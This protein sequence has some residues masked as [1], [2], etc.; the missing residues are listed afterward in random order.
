MLVRPETPYFYGVKPVAYP[1]FEAS[2]SWPGEFE[3]FFTANLGYK[4][5][6]V[7]LH[8]LLGYRVL[9]DLQGD[10]VL[11]GR[12]GWLFLRQDLGWQAFRSEVPLADDGADL[13]RRSLKGAQSWLAKREIPF[14]YVI[15]PNKDTIYPD[16]LPGSATRARATTRLDEMLAL[17]REAGIEHLELRSALLEERKRAQVYDRIDSHWNGLG[18]RAG[19]E[20]IMKRA[21]EL[22]HRPPEFA[23]LN[24]RVVDQKSWADLALLLSLDKCIT[25]PS[26]ALVPREPRARRVEPPEDVAEPNRKQQARMVYEVPD[27]S[28]PTALIIR[29]SFSE[30]LAPVLAEKF[31]RSVWLWTHKLDLSQVTREKP[32]IVIVETAERFLSGTP[33][34]L[35]TGPRRR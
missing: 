33:P 13:W 31:R 30:G 27:D 23:E 26:K 1:A 11:V 21:A 24:A 29:D 10:S 5:R 4:Q 12:Q 25:E 22:L 18:A 3:Q 7:Q 15:V 17:L 9:G 28:L 8:N 14:L 2:M 19:A 16:F 35:I 34:R 6:L 20:L 32:D